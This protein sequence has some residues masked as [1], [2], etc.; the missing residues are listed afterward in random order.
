M[1]MKQWILGITGGIAA[2]KTPELIRLM[3]KEG[4][5]VK[6]VLSKGAQ[7]FVT[8]MTLQ[9][10]SG[11]PVYCKLLDPAFEAAMGHIELARWAEGILIAP[12]SANRL[13]ALAHGMADDLL[14]TLCLATTAPIYVAP[15]MNQQMWLK[16]ATQRNIATLESQGITV[17]G[18]DWGEQACKEVGW[19]RMLEPEALV[20]QLFQMQDTLKDLRV[21]ITAGPTREFI[22][23]VRFLSNRSSGKMGFALA[24]AAAKMGAK[25]TLVSGP[26]K[27]SRPQGV[28]EIRVESAQQMQ[29]AILA[30]VDKV[31]IFISTAA[32]ADYRVETISDQKIK[33]HQNPREWSLKLIQNPDILAGV[34]QLKNRPFCVGFAA[35]TEQLYE[36]AKN[37]LKDKKIDLIAV[38][39]VSQTDI[40]F[41]VDHNALQVFSATNTYNISKESK[42]NVAIQLLKIIK[43]NYNAKSKT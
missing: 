12:L 10:V 21:L 34:A 31:D 41:D 38:N 36:N 7:S 32:V 33:K 27:L 23:P 9:A 43:E 39:D 19:G 24:Q 6:A 29:Q 11:N 2:Y 30:E 4:A 28:T 22:D 5:Q 16:P 18:P 3:V 20:A 37:K 35:E 17:L 1:K 13:A 42:Q 40:G 8:P 25:V 14:T 15:A 26:V